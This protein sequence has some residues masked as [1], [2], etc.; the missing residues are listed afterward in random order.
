MHAEI[1]IRIVPLL[2]HSVC[3]MYVI[4]CLYAMH[5]ACCCQLNNPAH[6]H[7]GAVELK[8]T[9]TLLSANNKQT[10]EQSNILLILMI[11]ACA[12]QY[13]PMG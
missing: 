7:A 3:E 13:W 1:T 6:I 4:A 10:L 5:A 11:Y 12:N 9:C 8:R 2:G